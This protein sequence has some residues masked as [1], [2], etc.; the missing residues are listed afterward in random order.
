[1]T[2]HARAARWFWL[3]L[4]YACA[5]LGV[6]GIFVPGLPTVPFLLLASWAA[7]RGSPR[8]HAW[9]H[10]HPRLSPLLRDWERERAI[11][12]RA[13]MAA[14]IL[15][16]ISWVLLAWHLEHVLLTGLLGV[17]FLAVG[18]FILSRP[19]PRQH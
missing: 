5:G 11:S 8:L 17:L 12:R 10:A 2:R 18:A 4:A 14:I 19:V 6:L 1:M 16:A 15:L 9:L 7:T 13:K 3:L